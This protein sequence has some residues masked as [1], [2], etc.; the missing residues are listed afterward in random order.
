MNAGEV[1]TCDIGRRRCR[2][3]LSVEGVACLKDDVVARAGLGDRRQRPM[4]PIEA[5]GIIL[6]GCSAPLDLDRSAHGSFP[7]ALMARSL[8]MP[9]RVG[10]T[11][12]IVAG[13]QSN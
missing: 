13:P 8:R 5:I 9:D 7:P 10:L 3:E 6:C 11:I 2:A 1:G 4:K 12:R